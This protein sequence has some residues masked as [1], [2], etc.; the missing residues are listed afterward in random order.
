MLEAQL[1]VTYASKS[2]SRSDGSAVTTVAQVLR[3]HGDND[4]ATRADEAL[5]KRLRTNRDGRH[6]D[7]GQGS[8]VIHSSAFMN[9]QIKGN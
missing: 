2:A 3:E 5:Q 6:A 8:Y 7:S 9:R 4:A 1:L